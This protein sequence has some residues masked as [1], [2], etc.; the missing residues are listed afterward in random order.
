MELNLKTEHIGDDRINISWND[1]KRRD[2]EKGAKDSFV[3]LATAFFVGSLALLGV[4]YGMGRNPTLRIYTSFCMSDESIYLFRC[5]R[6]D[7]PDFM[8]A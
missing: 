5:V 6:Q 3:L 8:L 7:C 4:C 2:F 1:A